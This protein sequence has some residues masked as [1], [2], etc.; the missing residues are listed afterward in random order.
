RGSVGVGG[1]HR[2][3]GLEIPAVGEHGQ[4]REESPLAL[5]E[6]R[7]APL[8]RR[9]EGALSGWGLPR[10]APEHV[11]GTLETS[12][13]LLRREDTDAGGGELDGQRQ[14]IEPGADTGDDILIA[15]GNVDP[16]A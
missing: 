7:L 10:A 4:P 9:S 13:D 14:P 16:A 1:A 15:G 8:Q 12:Q 5:A 6:E 3:D 11:E 2:F